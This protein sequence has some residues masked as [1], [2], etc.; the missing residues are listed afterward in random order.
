MD[1]DSGQKST[2]VSQA[3]NWW[4]WIKDKIGWPWR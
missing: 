4:E 1:T 2:V 3:G